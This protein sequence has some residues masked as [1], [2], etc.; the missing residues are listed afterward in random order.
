[1]VGRLKYSTVY[2]HFKG[3]V[4][5]KMIL[6][7]VVVL[8]TGKTLLFTRSEMDISVSS[9]LVSNRSFSTLSQDRSDRRVDMPLAVVSL[10][11]HYVTPFTV[12]SVTFTIGVAST[13]HPQ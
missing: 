6:S 3:E 4:H 12:K 9:Y 5:P 7:V 11:P 13:P 1:M 8:H 2:S 10:T